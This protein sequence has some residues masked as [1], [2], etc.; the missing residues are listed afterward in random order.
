M[1]AHQTGHIPTCP[2]PVNTAPGVESL[3]TSDDIYLFNEG[4]HY[5]LYEKF[6]AHPMEM[7][8]RRGVMFTV[9]A[10]NARYVAVVGDFNEWDR[11]RNPMRRHWQSGVW[12]LFIEGLKPGA[13]YKYH[14]AS[15]VHTG[16]AADKADPFG[17]MHEQPP[18]TASIVRGIDYEWNDAEWMRVRGQA[19]RRDRPM[20]IY[21]VHVGSWMHTDEPREHA[22]DDAPRA[23]TYREL[24]P[25]LAAYVAE[26]GFTHVEFLPVME[27]PLFRSWGYQTTG[28]FAP[29]SRFGG[30]Q[31]YMFL[32]DTLHQA[33]MGVILDWVPSHFP[34]DE[35][36]LGYFDGTH[37]FEHADPRQGF[38]PDWKSLIFNYGRNEIRS[39][40]ISSALFWL[41]RYHA[42]GLRV[43]AVA[44]MLYLNY[45]REDG[46]WVANQHGGRE[47]LEA[48]DF[49][50]R[51]NREVYRSFPD[52]FTTAEESTAFPGVCLPPENGGLGFGYKWDMGWM[53]D[54]LQHYS[55]DPLYRK[56]N[57]NELTFRSMYQFSEN[58]VLPLS[59]DE[60]VHGK[61]TILGKM[62][63]DRWQKFANLRCLYVNQWTQ[64]GKKLLFMGAELGEFREWD[65]KAELS[66]SLLDYADHAGIKR[67]VTDLNRLYCDEP[68]LHECDCEDGGFQWLQADDGGAGVLA[69]LRFGKDPSDVVLVVLGT[70]PVPRENYVL[71]VPREGAWDEVLN[72]DAPI[73]GGSGIGNLGRVVA[74]EGSYQ[75]MPYQLS[76][77]VP[78][79]A[80][81]IFR[82]A[83]FEL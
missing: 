26:M 60:V 49:L 69:F 73:Y 17:F 24:A 67:L 81:V 41:D 64:P 56:H 57:H 59:H 33:G 76:V 63:G 7:D 50:Q 78:P 12:E 37:L 46:E 18:H 80:G 20:S 27:H 31:D 35:H 13:V 45:S 5:R 4:T 72:S 25:R 83:G 44:S 19:A 58:Y 51:L 70:T 52:V 66:W 22:P 23:L 53:H 74:K 62:A 55:R 68:A 43:D 10:P 39:F 11:G 21:E 14:V 8:G 29:T 28:Y 47:N 48:I 2:T 6:G 42:D 79:L 30:P 3:L 34:S 65:E 32:V 15:N 54:T 9:W 71:G 38:H 16:Y 82:P 77:T 75:G 1:T 61:G 36:G 40:L